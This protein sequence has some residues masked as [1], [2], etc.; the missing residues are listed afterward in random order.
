M[1]KAVAISKANPLPTNYVAA[2]AALAACRRVDECKT[3]ADK[4]LALKSYAKQMRDAALE[5]MAQKI[6]DRAVLRGGELLD[7][8]KAARGKGKATDKSVRATGRPNSRKATAEKA[9]ISPHEAK[10][11]IR[12]A[13]VPKQQFEA[14]VERDKPATVKELAAIGTRKSERVKPAPYR[15]EWIGWMSAVRHL[16]SLPACGLDVL[17]ERMPEMLPDL[18]SNAKDALPN[19]TAWLSALEEANGRSKT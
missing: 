17:A 9:G 5:D 12:V 2:K 19:L 18:T 10:Q 14:M 6:R 15:D 8:I 16:A 11:M 1:S 4:A 13:R 3:W 7:A